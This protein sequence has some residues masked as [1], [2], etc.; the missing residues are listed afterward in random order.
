MDINID[1]IPTAKQAMYHASTADELLYGGAAGGGK[2]RAT[3]ME[4]FIDGM[5]NPG[6]DTYLFRETMPSSG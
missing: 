5:E 2:S 4:A 1:Y 6:V 3:V